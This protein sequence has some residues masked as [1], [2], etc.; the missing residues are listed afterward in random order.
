MI[1][2]IITDE[3]R[4]ANLTEGSSATGLAPS[5]LEI[6]SYITTVGTELGAA[7]KAFQIIMFIEGTTVPERGDIKLARNV[8]AEVL[9]SRDGVLVRAGDLDEEGYGNTLAEASFDLLTS[10][11]DRY[12]SL[13]RRIQRLA[14]TE[15]SILEKL[16]TTL[17]QNH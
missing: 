12:I 17:G 3:T 16:R 10:L 15:L 13:S 14:D 11:Y 4:N 2:R 7:V 8:I 9:Y 1:V 5:V 6:V